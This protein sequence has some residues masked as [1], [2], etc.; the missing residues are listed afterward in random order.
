MGGHHFAPLALLLLLS[1]ALPAQERSARACADGLDNDG[2]GRVDCADPDCRALAGGCATCPN[3]LS[4]ADTVLAY[5]SGCGRS[6]ENP[7][8]VIGL[9]DFDGNLGNL[10]S[11]VITGE[12]GWVRLGFTN[13]ILINS[14]DAAPDVHVFEVEV[15]VQ[16]TRV[17][18]RP[19]DA[20]TRNLLLDRNVPDVDS[21]GYFEFGLV[22]P[23]GAALDLDAE[24]GRLPRGRLQFDAIEL[25]DLDEGNCRSFETPGADLDAVCALSSLPLVDC[26]GVPLGPHRYDH[27]GA[28]LLPADPAF[29]TACLDCA[30]VA[31]GPAVRDSCGD[32]RLPDDPTFNA[33]CTDCAGTVNGP[34]VRDSCGDCRPPDDPAF[35]AAC[36]DCAGVVNGP[37]RTDACGNCR[38]TLSREFNLGC[39]P[40]LRVYVP[41]AF[42]PDADGA[43][44]H[45][46]PLGDPALRAVVENFTVFD[47]WGTGVFSRR[48][49]PLADVQP[50][51]DGTYRGRAAPAG[52]YVYV[53]VVRFRDG[54]RRRL[55]GAVALLR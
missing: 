25:L 54:T 32:C 31:D 16:E 43:N 22:G 24:V 48:D 45:F 21:N 51:W 29:G 50:G 1:L 28:C 38:D 37:A 44:D 27:C 17:A 52:A 6:S 13:N 9:T 55:S 34:A 14:G 7:R 4:F 42:S 53:L 49:L 5:Q 33:A 19:R 35:N 30:G 40:E 41:T 47:R 20:A 18:L 46:A 8:S 10:S 11:F 23:R 2:D 3:G 15:E 39:G 36:R 12:G 26:A